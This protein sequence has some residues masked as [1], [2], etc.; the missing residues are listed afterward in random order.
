MKIGKVVENIIKIISVG[1]DNKN[2]FNES[3]LC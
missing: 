1:M 2:D 3:K